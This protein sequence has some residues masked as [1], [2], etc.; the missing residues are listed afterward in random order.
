MYK[1]SFWRK[2]FEMIAREY[3]VSPDHVFAISNGAFM[4]NETDREIKEALRK[5]GILISIL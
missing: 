5:K 3:G 1:K 2:E 4:M